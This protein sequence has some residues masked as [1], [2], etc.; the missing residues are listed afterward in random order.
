MSSSVVHLGC[1][2]AL[3]SAP[4]D[5]CRLRKREG[6]DRDPRPGRE[7]VAS[8]ETELPEAAAEFEV[9]AIGHFV[10]FADVD[11]TRSAAVGAGS[12]RFAGR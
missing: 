5:R 2:A 9:V 4:A 8:P 1:A 3:E 12:W 7:R 10:V 6:L 11:R